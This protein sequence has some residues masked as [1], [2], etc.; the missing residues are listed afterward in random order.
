MFIYV[1]WVW[2]TLPALASGSGDV[3]NEEDDDIDG[4]RKLV[5]FQIPISGVDANNLFDAVPSNSVQ[6]EHSDTSGGSE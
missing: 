5:S 2:R 6:K 4:L 1:A 3:I